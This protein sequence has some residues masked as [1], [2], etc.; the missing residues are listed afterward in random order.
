MPTPA[1]T[2]RALLSGLSAL[3]LLAGGIVAAAPAVAADRLDPALLE[4]QRGSG[5]V[6]QP[7]ATIENE[8]AFCKWLTG[9]YVNHP[10]Y[11]TVRVY[12]CR[13][14]DIFVKAVYLNGTF[15]TCVLVPARH[16]RHLGGS[17]VKPIDDAQIC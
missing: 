10:T 6:V 3:A 4:V 7:F 8:E 12:N 11:Y 14:T 2:R 5:G 16:S 13:S 1:R 17:I 9:V 15:G